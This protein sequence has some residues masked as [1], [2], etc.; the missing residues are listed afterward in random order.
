M[1]SSI[2]V[3]LLGLFVGCGGEQ[4]E[5][6]TP[7]PPAPAPAPA[8]PPAAQVAASSASPSAVASAQPAAQT[9]SKDGKRGPAHWKGFPG[10][11]TKATALATKRA[12]GVVP[13]GLGD[14]FDVA[15]IAL[16]D[17]GKPSGEEQLLLAFDKS[18]IYVPAGLVR[19]AEPAKGVAKG[20]GI[21]VNVAAASGYGRVLEV[22]K[23]DEGDV[24]SFKYDWGGS[25][26]DDPTDLPVDQVVKLED[27]LS[28]GQPVAVKDGDGWRFGELVYTDATT[29][30]VLGFAGKPEQVATKDLKPLKVAKPIAKGAKVLAEGPGF[31]LVPGKVTDVL[32]GG[33]QYK[34]K[35]DDGKEEKLPM[36]KVSAPLN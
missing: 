13:V 17:Y 6:V 22:K 29:S 33:A 4:P 24:V 14:D 5:P 19:P 32:G 10:P 21:M 25:I 9:P 36:Q 11:K 12:W 26:D 30:W 35:L 8:P 27:K 20:D 7:P 15:K 28:F 3:V 1:R 31:R 2:A 23:G 18:E 16:Q 34:V